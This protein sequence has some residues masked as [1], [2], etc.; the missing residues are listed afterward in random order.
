MNLFMFFAIEVEQFKEVLH[1]IAV[2]S[3]TAFLTILFFPNK[4]VINKEV[5]NKKKTKKTTPVS[6]TKLFEKN[7]NKFG[8]H[9]SPKLLRIKPLRRT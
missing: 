8:F 5:I 6:V 7:K 4:E 2:I 1:I 9:S 3:L